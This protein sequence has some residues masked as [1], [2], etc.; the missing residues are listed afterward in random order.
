MPRGGWCPDANG[1]D[2]AHTCRGTRWSVAAAF[3]LA[4]AVAAP[5]AAFAASGASV[6]AQ[7]TLV[8]PLTWQGGP[9][10]SAAPLRSLV[11]GGLNAWIRSVSAGRAW[12]TGDV[13][14]PVV[15]AATPT[16]DTV[17]DV[18]GPADGALAA[19]GIDAD[20][21][22]RVLYFLPA[23]AGCSFRGLGEVGGR[24]AWFTGVSDVATV[25][26]E[27]GHLLGL[28]HAH[29]EQCLQNAFAGD[30]ATLEY[31]DWWDTM[32]TG[33]GGAYNAPEQASLGW[34]HGIT[35]PAGDADVT[36]SPLEGP[37]STVRAATVVSALGTLWLEHRTRAVGTLRPH[38]DD[39][40]VHLAPS[41]PYGGTTLPTVPTQGDDGFRGAVTIARP[42]RLADVTI[43]VE[44]V[45]GSRVVVRITR[46][47]PAAPAPARGLAAAAVNGGMRLRWAAAGGAARY[48]VVVDGHTVAT[49]AGTTTTVRVSRGRHSFAVTAISRAW[50]RSGATRG[51]L[52]LAARR[53]PPRRAR[54]AHR[55]TR[56]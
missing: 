55:T 2:R 23:I 15:L 27:F 22:P 37:D 21:Y 35:A 9:A 54:S 26:H 46:G 24:H 47:H 14:D 31:G 8:V 41:E 16:C 29:A 38:A 17:L 6:G 20:G 18:A 39:V 56:R 42:L 5:G 51:S 19:R 11:F 50:L 32:G 43:A 7:R 12:V 4:C 28:A 40:L 45:V 1:V 13:A 49:V 52:R 10:T 48:A 44:G 25:A 34:L 33:L 30:C 36:L 53:A 3:V